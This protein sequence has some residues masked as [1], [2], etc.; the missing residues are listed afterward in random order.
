MM[1][2]MADMAA[3]CSGVISLL[4][5]QISFDILC[6]GSLSDS[7]H[8]GLWDG[9]SAILAFAPFPAAENRLEKC[10]APRASVRMAAC[11]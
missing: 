11:S 8:P 7:F 2:A 5:I 6:S 10:R 3:A 9:S 1:D 4:R